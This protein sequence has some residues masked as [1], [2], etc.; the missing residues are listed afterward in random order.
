M[1]LF[2]YQTGRTPC[3]FYRIILHKAGIFLYNHDRASA[4]SVD[5]RCISEVSIMKRFWCVLLSLLL[6]LGSV[7]FAEGSFPVTVTDAAGREVTIEKQPERIVSGYYISTSLLIALGVK[8][9]L[10]GIEAKADKRAIY[11]LSSP[12]LIAL[13]SVGSAKQPDVEMMISLKPD[14][15]ILPKKLKDVAGTLEE[16]GIP[17]ILVNPEDGEQL[18]G[19]ITLLATATGS[20]GSGLLEEYDR[21]EGKAVSLTEG[22]ERPAVYLAGNSAMLST[23]GSG[24]YQNTLLT[25]AGGENVAAELTGGS[26]A[27]ISYEQ[28]LAWNPEVI[29]LAADASY[30]VADVMDDPM[31][32]EL[33]AVKNGKVYALPA[34]PEAWDSPVPGTILGSLWIVSKLHPEKYSEDEFL[35]D[36]S[37]FYT[38][39]FGFELTGDILNK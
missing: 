6:L 16:L 17:V 9:Q 26:W 25:L 37:G 20:D 32:A 14:L 33:P 22:C 21:L 31:L 36:A 35:A 19:T 34:A 2:P 1:I 15:V 18:R 8:D 24:M 28:L 3:L 5:V 27:D 39:F 4:F 12:E 10:V 29:I 7:S 23:A 38:R 30:T 11:S 13:P